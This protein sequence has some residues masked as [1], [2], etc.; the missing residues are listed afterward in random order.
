MS[1]EE[2]A[3]SDMIFFPKDERNKHLAK[4]GMIPSPPSKR[5]VAVTKKI[6]LDGGINLISKMEGDNKRYDFTGNLNKWE[7]DNEAI[8]W[9]ICSLDKQPTQWIRG[10]GDANE[11]RE[12]SLI[13]WNKNV[14]M[15]VRQPERFSSE[16]F[17]KMC[18]LK[19]LVIIYHESNGEVSVDRRQKFK[20]PFNIPTGHA[21]RLSYNTGFY[22][23]VVERINRERGTNYLFQRTGAMNPVLKTLNPQAINVKFPEGPRRFESHSEPFTMWV[24]P[25][26][27]VKFIPQTLLPGEALMRGNTALRHGHYE[28]FAEPG[29]YPNDMHSVDMGG[30]FIPFNSFNYAKRDVESYLVWICPAMAV[31]PEKGECI[32]DGAIN[33]VMPCDELGVELGLRFMDSD[34]DCDLWPSKPVVAVPEVVPLIK[35]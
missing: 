7:E 20:S 33:V 27:D 19:V 14:R 17:F 12:R 6:K 23:S 31:D 22:E 35:E 13:P 4:Y 1:Y 24:V 29:V 2:Y 11:T 32:S 3:P 26:I 10:N 16:N 5:E 15:T 8:F 34:Y 28:K 18:T 30:F 21:D 9:G 25:I